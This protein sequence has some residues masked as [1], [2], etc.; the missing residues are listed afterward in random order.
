[1]PKVE[2]ECTTIH[3]D[4]RKGW[5]WGWG[6]NSNHSKKTWMW[7]TVTHARTNAFNMPQRSWFEL[8]T[9]NLCM[10]PSKKLKGVGVAK[11]NLKPSKQCWALGMKRWRMPDGMGWDLKPIMPWNTLW[12]VL[13]HGK[14]M[15]LHGG[16]L[17]LPCHLC[18]WLAV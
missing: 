16:D 4:E 11:G 13:H 2:Q 17:A 6:T 7:Y 3:Q 14:G 12:Q 8:R 5:P 9:T 1:M 15:A 10:V 18:T